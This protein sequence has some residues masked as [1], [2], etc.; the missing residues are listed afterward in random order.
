MIPTNQKA[1]L[2]I[3]RNESSWSD[4]YNKLL[5]SKNFDFD[6]F[7]HTKNFT[8]TNK[9]HLYILSDDKT[10]EGDWCIQLTLGGYVE[11]LVK[12]GENDTSKLRKKI[13][14]TTDTS[15][16]IGRLIHTE[17]CQFLDEKEFV[18]KSLPQPSQQFIEKYAE[19]YNSGKPIEEVEVE[20]EMCETYRMD[21]CNSRF[22]CCENP[23]KLKINPNNTINTKLVKDYWT[24]DEVHNLMMQA[25]IHGQSKPDCHYMVREKWIEEN[26]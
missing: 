12:V 10:K 8:H 21:E 11:N 19:S 24:R 4:T 16:I 23:D 18:Q 17:N 9:Q 2:M 3:D 13:V 26:L 1:S 14:A 20:Y 5:Y 7:D 22:H 25:W 6:E 15:L